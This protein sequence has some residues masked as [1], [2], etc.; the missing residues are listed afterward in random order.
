MQQVGIDEQLI[1][2]LIEN[3]L[4]RERF[5]VGERELNTSEASIWLSRFLS[6]TL[7][8]AIESLPASDGV[9]EV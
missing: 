6:H 7:E 3:R 1:T 8:Y 4:D 9:R 5:Y 2:G